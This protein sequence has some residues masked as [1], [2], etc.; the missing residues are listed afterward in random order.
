M[1]R[2]FT[3][4]PLIVSLAIFGTLFLMPQQAESQQFPERFQDQ[5]TPGI[6]G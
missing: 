1:I 2:K 3:W 6:Y 4:Y 5:F